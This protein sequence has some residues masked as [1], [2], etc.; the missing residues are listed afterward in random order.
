METAT[1][2]KAKAN[3]KIGMILLV[4][5]GFISLGLPDGL[6]GV[7]WPTMRAGFGIPLDALGMLLVASMCGYFTSSFFSGR[8]IAK[9]GVGGL[10]AASCA[11]T[12]AAL[13]GY[14]LAPGWGMIVVL[15][16]FSGLG[17]GA[18]D[19]G[20]NT[21]VAANFS[22]GLMQWLHASFGVGVTLG[23]IIMTSGLNFFQTWRWGYV[24]VG[25][26]QLCLAVCFAFTIRM[27]RREKAAADKDSEKRLTDYKTP[28]GE[29]LRQAPV[30]VSLLLFFIYT[31]TEITLGSWA[32]TLL[33]ESR[34]VAPATAGLV[35]GSYWGMFTV[36]RILAGLYTRK[37]SLN[38]LIRGSLVLA[39]V[40]AVLLWWNPSSTVSLIGVAICGF[41]VAPI[42]PGLVSG[43]SSRVGARFA[44]N[45]IGMQIAAAG[46]G[47]SLIP[48]F[49]GVLARRISLEVVPVCMV[50]FA[51]L[52][53]ALY[54]YSMKT[55]VKMEPAVQTAD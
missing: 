12:G 41:A 42:F 21:Y 8:I 10:L 55:A 51:V 13:L 37:I 4:Y 19:A 15:G 49:V 43:T 54:Q 29:T 31:G 9:M 18:I 39:L 5:I 16:V 26:A 2:T 7:A 36:G 48:G 38:T 23:P 44:A 33:T 53:L 32:Y 35:A 28:L 50:I 6:L 46:L 52:L 22:E 47:G 17:A 11:T 25:A 20:I 14:T 1:H 30:W 34:G 27:W 3:T 40:G 24:V 45:T